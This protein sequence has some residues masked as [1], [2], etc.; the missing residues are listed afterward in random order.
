MDSSFVYHMFPSSN[1]PLH[2]HVLSSHKGKSLLFHGRVFCYRSSW[3]PTDLS[4]SIVH[5]AREVC[6]LVTIG[7]YADY[8]ASYVPTLHLPCTRASHVSS[9]RQVTALL[10]LD[11]WRG[12]PVLASALAGASKAATSMVLHV[13]KAPEHGE[14]QGIE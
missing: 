3:P 4:E 7:W 1:N 13:G 10:R 6:H 14:G 2:E 9:W 11:L 5:F 12:I 8:C